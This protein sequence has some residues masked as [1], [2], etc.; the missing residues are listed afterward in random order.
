MQRSDMV[1]KRLSAV[2]MPPTSIQD[3]DPHGMTDETGG[4]IHE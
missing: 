3:R 2:S 1:K 4:N